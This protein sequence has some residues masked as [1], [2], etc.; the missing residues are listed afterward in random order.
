MSRVSHE[1]LDD[2]PIMNTFNIFED[3]F[4][5][6]EFN[7][8]D[9]LEQQLKKDPIPEPVLLDIVVSDKM[10]EIGIEK[11]CYES[12]NSGYFS[13]DPELQHSLSKA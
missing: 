2:I 9:T 11:P 5:E 7:P 10:S 4:N 6:H 8:A 13:K 1:K 3:P 12:L